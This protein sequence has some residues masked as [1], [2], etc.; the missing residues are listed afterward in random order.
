MAHP[1]RGA[2]TGRG[3]AGG[4]RRSRRRGLGGPRVRRGAFGRRASERAAGTERAANGRVSDARHHRRRPRRP[5]DGQG[6][7]PADRPARRQ[8]GDGRQHPRAASRADAAP[9]AGARHGAVH[10]GRHPVELH[11]ARADARAGGHR[12]EPD[13]GGGARPGVAHD[14]GRQ[15]R[16]GGVG[17][18]AG[19]LRRARVPQLRGGRRADPKAAR[20]AQGVPLDRGAAR[21]RA[22]SRAIVPDPRGVRDGP[23]GRFP[24][25]VRRTPRG[26]PAGRPAGP[27]Q[28]RPRPRQ[29]KDAR[30]ADGLT[31]SVRYGAQRAG[32]RRR[33]GRGA[34]AERAREGQQTGRCPA[35]ATSRSH[36]GSSTCARN[37]RRPRPS[38]WSGSC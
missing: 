5:R 38:R 20:E 12:L 35:P 13:R 36:C 16:R 1:P 24:R 4:W 7:L 21:L 28:G 31:P 3:A 15:S 26:C 27:R 6:P 34:A 23:R 8:C 25:P 29:G 14:L 22:G 10:P 18:A 37:N 19:R 11:P 17:C 33:Q 30:R 2:C 32:P 9:D